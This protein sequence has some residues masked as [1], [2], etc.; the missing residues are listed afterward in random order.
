MAIELC[1]SV[2]KDQLWMSNYYID[3]IIII[4]IIIDWIMLTHT[5]SVA[6]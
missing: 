1:Q 4:I 3:Y 6:W 5:G 2:T